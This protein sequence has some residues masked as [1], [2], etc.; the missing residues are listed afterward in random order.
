MKTK[1]LLMIA[2][3]G[4]VAWWLWQKY[5]KKSASAPAVWKD[6][7]QG[8]KKT[9]NQYP[10]AIGPGMPGSPGYSPVDMDST[11]KQTFDELTN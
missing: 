5:G 1:T 10:G 8:G 3:A 6:S 2:G 7:Y 4:L 11:A 9:A